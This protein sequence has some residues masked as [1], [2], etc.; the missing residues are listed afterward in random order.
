MAA[1]DVRAHLRTVLFVSDDVRMRDAARAQMIE[2]GHYALVCSL[3]DLDVL[4]RAFRIDAFIV[5]CER[6]GLALVKLQEAIAHSHAPPLHIA[7]VATA[8]EALAALLRA[9]EIE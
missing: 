7:I 4:V 8:E 5:M 3:D 6:R 2:R 9:C 1:R